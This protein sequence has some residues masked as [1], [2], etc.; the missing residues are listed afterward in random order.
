MVDQVLA[1][2]EGTQA[3]AAGAR[4]ARAQGRASALFAELAPRAS[5]APASTARSANSTT[6]GAGA[7][8]RSTASKWWWTASR[9]ATTCAAPGRILRDGPDPLRRH[10]PWIPMDGRG[11]TSPRLIFSPLRLP[12]SAATAISRAGTALFSFNNPAGACPTCDGLGVKQFFDPTS[13]V[14]ND[15]LISL[16][17]GAIR[18]WDRRNVLLF[19]D[20]RSSSGRALRLRC[21]GP[22]DENCPGAI[23]RSSSTAAARPKIDFKLP[24]RRG[25][26]RGRSSTPSK[27]SCPTWS[28]ATGRRNPTRCA[29]SWPSYLSNQPCPELQG[30]PPETRRRAMS[31]WRARPAGHHRPARRRCPDFF[32]AETC[33]ASAARSP[34]RSSR[35]SPSGCSFLVNVGLDYLTLERS[36]ETLS[37][38][39]AQRIRLASQI[40]AGL[41][42]VMYILDEPSIGLHQRDNERLLRT[43]FHL[44]DLGNTVIVVEH[45]E[46]A[47]RPPITWWISAPGP[48]CTA[49]RSSPRAPPRRSCLPGILDR[50]Y[51]SGQLRIAIP[52]TAHPHRPEA[53]VTPA[54]GRPRQQPARRRCRQIPVGTLMLRHRRLGLR[55][56]DPDQRHPLSPRRTATSTTPPSPASRPP[57]PGGGPGAPR[58]GGGYRPEPH[59]P[60]PAL[61][62]GHLYRPVQSDPRTLRRR[63]RR[64]APAA[65]SPGRF[66]FNVKGGRCEACQGD[67]VIKVEMHFLPDVYVPCDVCKGKRYNRETLEVKYK[68]K[69]IHEV[70]EMTV[71]R[72]G[73]LRCRAG[74]GA[75]AADPDGRGPLLHPPGPERHHPV[76]RRGA[77]GQAQP[78]AVQARHGPDP[79]HPGRADHGAALPR[80][81]AIAGCAAPPAGS[82]QH[83]GG[84]R[85]QPGRHQDR[86]LGHRP[87]TRGRHRG[88][89]RSSPPA[90]RSRWP[91]IPPPIPGAISR[92]CW[93]GAGKAGNRSASRC[94]TPPG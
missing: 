70:L 63:A 47:I 34:R 23:A 57:R 44:R 37:G 72:P 78:R 69:N 9:C 89:A 45:D 61:Q 90:P 84:H 93:S 36:A 2:P 73:V 76:R 19:P 53:P 50:R 11:R 68:G 29:R 7:S 10:R 59:R 30:H 14:V 20:A 91:P 17:E 25:D 52:G 43:L 33:R 62:P 71:E 39:E 6:P 40:G 1:L 51:L 31:S 42:G 28:A 38:G 18:G 86:R 92:P 75:Q 12:A 49:A 4:D 46:D 56:V 27:A 94:S 77:A 35:R 24:E 16:A 58:Q 87:G 22:L 82:R 60:H 15:E 41:V 8:T 54:Q 32:G 64:R 55:Q 88:G 65:M 48:A 80:H 83:G 67:G 5:S 66:S 13:V 85:A 21:G 79:L 74:P 81:P 26:V 3:D